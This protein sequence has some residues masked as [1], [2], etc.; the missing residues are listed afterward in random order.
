MDMKKILQNF[1]S[2]KTKSKVESSDMKKFL[3]IVSESSKETGFEK[4]F[5]KQN[6]GETY[7]QYS[8]RRGKEEDQRQAD[9]EKQRQDYI[10]RGIIKDTKTKEA[11]E[12][13]IKDYFELI[14]AHGNSKIYDKCWKGYKK[15]PGKKR[16]EKGSC[17]KK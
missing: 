15:V 12:M 5:R 13:T 16:G 17:E 10:K 1:D 2:A 6:K 11:F 9:L 14:E 8:S 3:S 4:T 7:D